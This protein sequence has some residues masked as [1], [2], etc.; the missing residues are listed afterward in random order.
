MIFICPSTLQNRI[1]DEWG[2]IV[3]LCFWW[4][5]DSD[6]VC[7]SLFLGVAFAMISVCSVSECL[8]VHY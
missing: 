2:S 6:V 5:G 7:C 1:H 4:R 8:L 3:I